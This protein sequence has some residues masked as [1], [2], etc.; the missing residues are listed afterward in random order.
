MRMRLLLFASNGE[1]SLGGAEREN[2]GGDDDDDDVPSEGDDVG[3]KEAS[4]EED[5]PE[6]EF[7]KRAGRSAGK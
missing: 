7:R 3:A 4:V 6:G 5:D 2:S 1:A